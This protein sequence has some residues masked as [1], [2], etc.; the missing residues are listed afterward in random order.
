MGKII[1]FSK[2]YKSSSDY[3]KQLEQNIA[4]LDE[5]EN[6]LTELAI[7]TATEGKWKDWSESMQDGD[8]FNFTEEMLKDTGDE[9]VDNIA[10]LIDNVTITKEKMKNALQ[11]N[12]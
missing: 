12:V 3:Q 9:N 1:K 11:Q 2:G 6:N 7:N 8:E 10:S 5:I 4:K